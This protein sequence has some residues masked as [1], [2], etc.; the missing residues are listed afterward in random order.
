MLK[1]S[2]GNLKVPK[3]TLIINMSSAEECPAKDQC[4]F[5]KGSGVEGKD[6]KC[7]A[8]KA[9]RQYPSVREARKTQTEYWKSHSNKE[10]EE[11]F[12]SILAKHP[13]KAKSLKAVRFNESGDISSYED[14]A[15]LVNLATQ[16]PNITFYA[17]THNKKVMDTINIED[18]PEN[19]CIN[20]SYRHDKP[21]FNTFCLDT[22]YD[23]AEQVYDCNGNCTNCYLC[24]IPQAA[25]IKLEI[26]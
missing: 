16:H 25:N 5:S 6:G 17:Y 8:L 3:T 15:L 13:G 18:L 2:W 11:D 19:L 20:L 4:P 1:Y 26:H 21:G 9:E 22:D 14:I 12:A 23:E 24:L 7:Y 10:K